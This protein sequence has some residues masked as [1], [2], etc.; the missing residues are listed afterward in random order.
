MQDDTLTEDVS[1]IDIATEKNLEDLVKVGERL[2]KKPVS[3]VNLETDLIE[4][5]DEETNEDAL[6]RARPALF[7]PDRI[8]FGGQP[9]PNV[10]QAVSFLHK[11]RA[12]VE[13]EAK[14]SGQTE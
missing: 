7:G 6:Q 12:V 2:L 5:Y 13:G 1:S 4:P 8:S 11:Q 10:C 14:Q 9:A 3:R